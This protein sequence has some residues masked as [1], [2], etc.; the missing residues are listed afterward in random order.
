M[1]MTSI[2]SIIGLQCSLH[3]GRHVEHRIEVVAM[4]RVAIAN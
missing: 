4:V 2:S 3:V 1:V